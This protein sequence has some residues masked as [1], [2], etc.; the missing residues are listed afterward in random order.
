MRSIIAKKSIKKGE[1]FDNN[2]ITTKRPYVE[3]SIPAKDF[4]KHIGK[5]AL[6]DIEDDE[7]VLLKQS[8]LK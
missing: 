1:V 8:S 4:Y 2:N 5:F 6:N 7:I 3:G